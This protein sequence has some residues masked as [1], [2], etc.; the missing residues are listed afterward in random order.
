MG[1]SAPWNQRLTEPKTTKTMLVRPLVTNWRWLLEMTVLFPHG[2]FPHHLPTLSIKALTPCL[3]RVSGV[4][5]SWPL[6]R[7]LPTSPPVASIWNQTFVSTSLACL[8]AFERQAAR[9]PHTYLS[10]TLVS[11]LWEKTRKLGGRWE[12]NLCRGVRVIGQHNFIRL[13]PH[14]WSYPSHPT[15]SGGFIKYECSG[16]HGKLNQNF[17]EW[18]CYNVYVPSPPKTKSYIEILILNVIFKGGAVGR[19]SGRGVQPV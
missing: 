13:C 10:M 9:H 1:I 11:L 12:E 19:W 3:S 2:T 18:S 6:D 16:L 8:L 7:C 5:V 4:G 14:W 15:A 17:W